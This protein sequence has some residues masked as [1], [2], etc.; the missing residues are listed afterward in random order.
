MP[1]NDSIRVRAV[2]TAVAALCLFAALES[3][4]IAA[5]LAQQSPDTYGIQSAIARFAPVAAKL[6]REAIGYIGDLAPG[7][8]STVT[9]LGAQYALA[10]RLLL[11]AEQ[12]AGAKWAIGDFHRQQDF[13]AAGA[14]FGYEIAEQASNGIVLY[15]RKGTP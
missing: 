13:A 15:R 7:D 4:R 9:F 3:Y 1:S 2:A 8:Q 14:K 6:P 12:V 5:Q 11:P 10:P